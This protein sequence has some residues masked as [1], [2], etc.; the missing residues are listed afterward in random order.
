M[1]AWSVDPPT[2]S[3]YTSMPS[4]HSSEHAQVVCRPPRGRDLHDAASRV[5]RRVVLPA[6]GAEHQISCH[7]GRRMRFQDLPDPAR[8]HHVS[9][10]LWRHIAR[11]VVQK[12]PHGRI[13]RHVQRPHQDFAILRYR[14]SLFAIGEMLDAD[15]P[16]GPLNQPPLPK[17]GRTILLRYSAIRTWFEHP[18]QALRRDVRQLAKAL[19]PHRAVHAV[20]QQRLPRVDLTGGARGVD[21]AL[22]NPQARAHGQYLRDAPER[23]RAAECLWSCDRPHSS[24]V[25]PLRIDLGRRRSR[26]P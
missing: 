24:F 2:L 19:K 6:E 8:A 17:P 18:H 16:R 3:K 9:D 21:E 5:D 20:T 7:Q 12:R 4:G 14:D 1:A 25:D 23:A 15:H 13:E 10:R 11:P 22:P 26:S